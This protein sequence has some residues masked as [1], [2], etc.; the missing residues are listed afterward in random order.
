MLLSVA[1]KLKSFDKNVNIFCDPVCGARA[2]IESAGLKRLSFSRGWMGGRLFRLK[3]ACQIFLGKIGIGVQVNKMD[4]L[5]DISG[6]AFS[7]QWGHGPTRDVA[8]LAHFYKKQ[9]KPVIFLPQAFGPFSNDESKKGIRKLI[10]NTDLI[11]ARD[12]QSKKYL[13]DVFGP[14]AKIRLCPDITT[15]FNVNQIDNFEFRA[16]A[17]WVA[18]IPNIRITES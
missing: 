17:P 7:D 15:D 11:F 2:E 4:A 6:F 9:G 18:I 12:R 5:I 14:S 1:E 10:D 13:S 16:S 8:S 3:L